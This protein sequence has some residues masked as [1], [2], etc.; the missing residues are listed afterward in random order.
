MYLCMKKELY[1]DA[2]DIGLNEIKNIFTKTKLSLTFNQ[3]EYPF[4]YQHNITTLNAYI[5]QCAMICEQSL[6]KT[7]QQNASQLWLHFLDEICL[8]INSLSSVTAT[9]KMVVAFKKSIFTQLQEFIKQMC[10]Y[11]STQNIIEI[12]YNNFKGNEFS[13]LNKLIEQM[14]KTF[15]NIDKLLKSTKGIQKSF[16]QQLVGN[17]IKEKEK[18]NTFVID[19]C[20]Y[21]KLKMDKSMKGAFYFFGCGH[22]VHVK[23]VRGKGGCPV[24]ETEDDDND[25]NNNKCGDDNVSVLELK[26]KQQ[27][28]QDE[29]MKM[30]MLHHFKYQHIVKKNNIHKKLYKYDK[31]YCE[32]LDMMTND[33]DYLF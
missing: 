25:N 27:Q 1:Q 21:C 7:T 24:C 30:E 16:I 19:V 9:T 28:Q 20:S 32:L 29:E 12:L 6:I 5:T 23:C 17:Y 2:L 10:C 3:H 4:E 31:S 14:M 26:H 15:S 18:G 22:V 33:D 8:M 13:L 11:V